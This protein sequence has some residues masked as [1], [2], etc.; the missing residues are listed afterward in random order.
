VV[1]TKDGQVSVSELKRRTSKLIELRSLE[2]EPVERA[3]ALHEVLW[4]QRVVWASQ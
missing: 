1:K 3:V 2:A 4:M